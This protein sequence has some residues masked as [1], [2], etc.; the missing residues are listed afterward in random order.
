MVQSVQSKYRWEECALNIVNFG[1]CNIDYVYKLEHI[2]R[3][4][5][6][7]HS[8][9]EEVFPGGKGLNQSIAI[10]RAGAKV[11]HAGC[12]GKDGEMLEEVLSESGVDLSFL[13]RVDTPC[14][15]AVIQVDDCGENAIFIFTGANG[16]FSV[17]YVDETLSHFEK[18]DLLILQ[19]EINNIGYIIDRAYEKGMKILLNPSPI[20]EA[21]LKTDLD[22]ISY[23]VLNEIEGE[24]LSGQ[25][26]PSKIITHFQ[27]VCPHLKV[28]LTL[29]DK[30][31]IYSDGKE[32]LYHP[33][34]EVRTVD[35]TAAG[36]TFTGY[37]AAGLARGI[38]SYEILKN[39][40][41]AAALSVAKKGAAPSIPLE[42]EVESALRTLQRKED[43]R[44][45]PARVLKE[46]ID[47]YVDT[48]LADAD[49]EGLAKELGY[50]PVYAGQL[51]KK[52]TGTTFS[53]YLLDKRCRAAA[54]ILRTSD[55]PI[56]EII[57]QVGYSNESYFRKAFREIY[58][59]GPAGYRKMMKTKG[60]K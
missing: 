35:S 31:C 33:A 46:L 48:A 25:K 38:P 28:V 18:G 41:A 16:C 5:E 32:T 24:A 57:G 17:S 45:K 12:V 40:C 27:K 60:G 10:A 15:H 47:G 52:A 8:Y 30:G 29:G 22:K 1:S 11:W 37:F 54:E 44:E 59:V 9:A 42:G 58:G 55:R 39:A 51:V 36:D 7:E 53:K 4:G 19:N 56:G 13:Q 20:D 50:S 3:A 23:L 49:I 26:Q 43:G 14:G 2:V 21:I 6:T 34:F